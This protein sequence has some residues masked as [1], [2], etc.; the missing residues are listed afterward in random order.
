MKPELRLR[1]RR[2]LERI[3]F[4]GPR[5]TR[6]EDARTPDARGLHDRTLLNLAYLIDAARPLPRPLRYKMA[7]WIEAIDHAQTEFFRTLIRYSEADVPATNAIE[8]SGRR[9]QL[10]QVFF[11]RA[12]L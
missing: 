10:M 11:R 6:I 12:S 8:Q 3:D 9:A 2:I 1:A 7:P 4:A 5:E